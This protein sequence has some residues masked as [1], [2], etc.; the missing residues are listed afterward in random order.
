[1]ENQ[2]NTSGNKIKD[3]QQ[4]T[5]Q[6]ANGKPGTTYAEDTQKNIEKA[7]QDK[8]ERPATS[9]NDGKSENEKPS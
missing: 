7:A 1:M 2:G 8:E 9:T 5:D 4:E 6:Q 3:I